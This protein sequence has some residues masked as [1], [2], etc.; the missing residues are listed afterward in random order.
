MLQQIPGVEI[1]LQKIKFD[2]EEISPETYFKCQHRIKEAVEA[3]LPHDRYFF[4]LIIVPN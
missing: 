1:R 2:S 3:L 4:F